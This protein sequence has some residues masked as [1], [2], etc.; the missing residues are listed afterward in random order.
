MP[1]RLSPT[2]RGPR[3]LRGP[4]TTARWSKLLL[5]ASGASAL[6]PVAL[7]DGSAAGEITGN[8]LPD[9]VHVGPSG[10]TV[11]ADPSSAL[12][13]V[14]GPSAVDDVVMAPS[15]DAI[16]ALNATVVER[17]TFAPDASGTMVHSSQV[18]ASG[19]GVGRFLR[20]G[21]LDGAGELDLAVVSADGQSVWLLDNAGGSYAVGAGPGFSTLGVIDD[22]VIAPIGSNDAPVIVCSTTL[23]L[24]F[25]T[26]AGALISYM[27]EAPDEGKLALSATAGASNPVIWVRR[28][29]DV[30]STCAIQGPNDV[31]AA[32]VIGRDLVSIAAGD[33]DA[34]GHS[35]LAVVNQAGR[36]AFILYGDSDGLSFTGIEGHAVGESHAYPDARPLFADLDHDGDLDLCIT[37]EDL[38]APK[39]VRGEV[40]AEADVKPT[41]AVWAGIEQYWTTE[42]PSDSTLSVRVLRAEASAPEAATDVEFSVWTSM[43]GA[44]AGEYE[45]ASTPAVSFASLG[46]PWTEDPT[47]NEEF[48]LLS[49]QGFEAGNTQAA[50]LYINLRYVERDTAGAVVRAWPAVSR[51]VVSATNAAGLGHVSALGAPSPLYT[52]DP[53][54]QNGNF[55]GTG[56]GTGGDGGEV[57]DFPPNRPPA[58][59]ASGT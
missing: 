42:S 29:G 15:G 26:A 19:F 57:P 49:V 13:R 2:S 50:V 11:V 8:G 18:V 34:S 7:A 54:P 59:G 33:F 45:T 22:L 10:I 46:L 20:Q 25:Y 28:Y 17:L 4:G 40:V 1:E 16:L 12:A 24:E 3:A 23:G 37:A 41:I 21:D 56:T 51:Y 58:G 31:G 47:F 14:T 53:H 43:P 38:T 52:H 27:V 39:L 30:Y 5:I 35:D 36:S 44:V 55:I 32:L 48:K 6:T 9:V